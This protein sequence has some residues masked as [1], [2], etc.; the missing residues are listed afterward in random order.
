MSEEYDLK[1]S[2]AKLGRLVPIIKDAHGNIIDG[3]HRKQVDPK[4]EEEF[5]IK[6]DSI[7]DPI[8]LLLA[9]MNIN[10][11]RRT[12][13]AE[14]KTQWL[15]E[16][17]EL[18]KWTPD[19]IAEKAGM[20]KRWVLQYMPK[21]LKQSEPEEL[22]RARLAR[23]KMPETP[24][25]PQIEQTRKGTCVYCSLDSWFIRDW[26]GQGVCQLCYERLQ[27]GEITLEKP[28]LKPKAI[29]P[30]PRVEVKVIKPEDTWE[31]RKATMQVPVSKMEESI[32]IKLEAKGL[33]PEVQKEFCLQRTR[34]DYYFPQ[35][36][37]AVYLDGEVHRGREDRDDD[38]RQ[39][40][41]R[42]HGVQVVSI[43]YEGS[44]EATENQIVQDIMASVGSS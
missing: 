22:E 30:A 7:T 39:L 19:E 35:Q 21:E 20:S 37:I 23:E 43:L 18:T 42:R 14:E 25:Q 34:P 32:L 36:N 24:K 15:K 6:L 29:E 31:H 1:E 9:R 2:V 5:S 3:F 40:L 16:L 27:K 38:L 44:S 26:E 8:Q 17:V 28:K 41:K 33:H 13:S 11:H 12:V 10:T 4:W